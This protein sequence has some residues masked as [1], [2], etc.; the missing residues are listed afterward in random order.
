M[1]FLVQIV[2]GI[3]CGLVLGFF[4]TIGVINSKEKEVREAW[5]V[6]QNALT[7]RY[8]KLKNVL[9][10]LQRHMSEFHTEILD[11]MDLCDRASDLDTQLEAISTY[12]ELENSI[13]Y[14]LENVKTS[15]SNYPSLQDDN[16][17]SEAIIAIAESEVNVG[18]AINLYNSKSFEYTVLLETFPISIASWI[19]NK[20]SEEIMQFSVTPA[21]EFQDNYID[22]D[23]I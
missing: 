4:T 9:N 21:N 17:V 8:L 23:E 1:S 19:L 14:K 20:N 18:E 16:E 3:A 12:L 6:L 2:I 15:M 10:F 5:S 7:M 22:E 11:I 13:N